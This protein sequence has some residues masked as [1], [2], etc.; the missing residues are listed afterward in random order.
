MIDTELALLRQ[1]ANGDL[2]FYGSVPEGAYRW[3]RAQGTDDGAIPA[4]AEVAL[5]NLLR[6]GLI[7]RE[8]RTHT[9]SPTLAGLV[10]LDSTT[11]LA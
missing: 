2:L 1:V 3:R 5:E 11:D 8:P 4:D 6:R 10:I 7:T 9:V